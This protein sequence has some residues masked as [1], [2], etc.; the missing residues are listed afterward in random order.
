MSRI[1]LLLGVSSP[2]RSLHVAMLTK[3]LIA[4]ERHVERDIHYIYRP[5]GHEGVWSDKPTQRTRSPALLA[6]RALQL[7][8][9]FG[10]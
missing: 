8:H 2:V 4:E 1:G 9:G 10:R 5:H 7:H 6:K 3:L